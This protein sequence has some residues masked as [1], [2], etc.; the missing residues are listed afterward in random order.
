MNAIARR[1][2]GSV[3]ALIALFAMLLSGLLL[4]STRAYAAIKV[5]EANP[6]FISLYADQYP[7]QFGNMDPG[8]YA[9]A[10]VDVHLD[11]SPVGDL[12][13]QLRRSGDLA[14]VAGGLVL[15]VERCAVPW[16]N[17]PSGVVMTGAPTCAQGRQLLDTSNE[18]DDYDDSS[19]IFDLG[20]IRDETAVYL[21]ARVGIPS[22]TLQSNVNARSAEFGLGLFADGTTITAPPVTPPAL[23]ITGVD[24]LSLALIAVGAI[25]VGI[26]VSRMRGREVA[27]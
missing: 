13:L 26:V 23:A 21:L 25:G 14:L 22:T 2:A 6:G 20:E 10:Q 17:V 19:P 27:E 4:L 7:I 24:V 9:Y 8:E 16:A 11:G 18:S 15:T 12:E 3:V 1:R 5:P